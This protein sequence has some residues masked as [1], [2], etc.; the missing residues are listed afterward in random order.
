MKP[1]IIQLKF[2]DNVASIKEKINN[3][4]T[5]RVLLVW[6]D[7]DHLTLNQLDYLMILRHAYL[8]DVQ[9]AFVLDEPGASNILKE[10]GVSIFRNIPEAQKKPWRKPK[11]IQHIDKNQNEEKKI[12]IKNYFE[13]N[14]KTK[15]KPN[16]FFQWLLFLIGIAA[17]FSLIL[18]I[19]PTANV[20]ITPAVEK[21][22]ITISVT[23][24]PTVSQVNLV[25]LVPVQVEEFVVEGIVE[26]VSSGST[27]IPDQF[28]SGEVLFRNLSDKMIAIPAGTVVRTENEPF[29]RFET[30]ENATL[31]QRFDSEIRVNVRSLIGGTAGNIS[32]SEITVIEGDFGADLVVY[33]P[34]QISGGS[35]IKTFSPTERDYE[36]VKSDLLDE[37]QNT[38]IDQLTSMYGENFIIPEQSIELKEILFEER[39]PEVGDPGERFTLEIK[40]NFSA[41]LLDQ[42]DL[43]LL[44]NLILD[45]KNNSL[46]TPIEGSTDFL[47]DEGSIEFDQQELIF[48]LTAVQQVYRTI[49][50]QR[51]TQLIIGKPSKE[52]VDIVENEIKLE[53]TPQ[54]S[55]FP[56][57]WK[58]MPLLSFRINLELSE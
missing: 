48:D 2:Y 1:T 57:F 33:N 54:I 55:I 16:I 28:A 39:I 42:K 29:I 38:A 37:L 15:K 18:F 40:A 14:K 45:T 9:I 49:D 6:P 47:I 3:S 43:N 46:F 32:A 34:E 12:L 19:F 11:L 41:W 13:E 50:E 4:P 7:F 52:A 31:P 20:T 8:L 44:S 5:Q 25:G 26:G 17:F 27:R 24:E 58:I 51:I 23:A 21:R 10:Y 35:D 30:V 56:N 53:S 36:S 22:T